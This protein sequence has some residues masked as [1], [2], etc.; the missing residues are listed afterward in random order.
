MGVRDILQARN[1]LVRFSGGRE[2]SELSREEIRTKAIYDDFY[3]DYLSLTDAIKA[4]ESRGEQERA[5]R[6]RQRLGEMATSIQERVEALGA[7]E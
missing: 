7:P 6:L 5:D 2:K 1:R 4:S 3:G